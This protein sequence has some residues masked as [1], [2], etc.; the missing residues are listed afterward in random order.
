M[1][2]AVITGTAGFIG[3]RLAAEALRLGW[4][5]VG[6]DCLRSYYDVGQKRANLAP[7][8]PDPAFTFTPADLATADLVPL[9]DGADVIFHLAGQP[10]VRGSWKAGFN[11]YCTDNVLATQRLLE[12]A[13]T[14]GVGRIVYSSSSSI[15]GDADSYPVTELTLPRPISPYGVSKLAG[16]HLCLAYAATGQ[17][18]AVALRYFTVYGPGQRPDMAMH[19]LIRAALTGAPFELYGDGGQVRDFTYVSDVVAANVLAAAA[20]LHTGSA[21]VNIAGGS[22]ATLAEVI[23]IIEDAAGIGINLIAG[24]PQA[25]DVRRTG[26]DTAV[27]TGLLEWQ[28]QIVLEEGIA[29]QLEWQTTLNPV[30]A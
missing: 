10:G 20:P 16:E 18:D 11:D 4:S 7:L 12:A 25:G 13:V 21:V 23:E 22:Q 9:L 26:G 30:P 24:R 19:R 28:P 3:S 8:E 17:I 5:V 6:L 27:A 14:A 2:R 29:R 1:M 15:Y